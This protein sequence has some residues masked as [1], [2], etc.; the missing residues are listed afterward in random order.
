MTR[1][2]IWCRWTSTRFRSDPAGKSNF[3]RPGV[4]VGSLWDDRLAEV[5]ASP[6]RAGCGVVIGAAGVVTARHVVAAVVD[7][8][9]AGE[10]LARVVRRG[11]RTS[12]VPMRVVA[13]AAEWDLAVLE[14]DRSSPAAAAWA[15]PG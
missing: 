15:R 2:G 12:W 7:G 9:A 10:V 13:A 6:S 3:V 14:V 4:D 11:T 5:W 8:S 1:P